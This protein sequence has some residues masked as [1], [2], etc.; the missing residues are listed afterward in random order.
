MNVY[1]DFQKAFLFVSTIRTLLF[2]KNK[3]AH[4]ITWTL[5]AN[6]K[7]PIN[8]RMKTVIFIIV[9]MMTKIKIF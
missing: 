2:V 9:R 5:L 4:I 8:G 7:L 1:T 3:N 6:K